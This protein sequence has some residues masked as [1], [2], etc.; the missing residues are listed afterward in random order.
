MTANGKSGGRRRHA[1]LAV[2]TAVAA[3]A[4]AG[5]A[6]GAAPGRFEYA[7]LDELNQLRADP[8]DYAALVAAMRSRFD[9]RILRGRS[10]DEIDILTHEGRPA[11]D[12]AVRALRGAEPVP[13]LAHGEVLAR[14][15]A[16]LAAE[17]GRSGGVGHRSN[18]RG[19]A[20]RVAARGGGPFVGEVITYGH[21]DPASVITQLVIG[22]GVPGRGHRASVLAREYRY[23][24]AG[25]GPHPVHRRMCVIVLSQTRDGSRPAP[26]RRPPPPQR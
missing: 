2:A 10:R 24:G 17:Q 12:E 22:D 15:A 13:E 1:R 5:A 4:A 21:S 16:D 7:V 6:A 19:P 25:C 20:E 3:V 14:A 11:V 8:A 26:V 23:A 9:G 18:G